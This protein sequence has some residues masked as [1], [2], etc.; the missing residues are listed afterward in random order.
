MKPTQKD[1]TAPAV[2]NILVNKFSTLIA[3]KSN[4]P[5]AE[6]LLHSLIVR[7]CCCCCCLLLL[8][9]L[10]S[11]LLWLLLLLLLLLLLSLFVCL[12]FFVLFFVF[13]FLFLF[14]NAIIFSCCGE[15]IS[16]FNTKTKLTKDDRLWT[17][18]QSYIH[19][20]VITYIGKDNGLIA[21]LFFNLNYSNSVDMLRYWWSDSFGCRLVRNDLYPG[22]WKLSNHS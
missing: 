4:Y 18:T 8:L 19:S 13:L 7:V 11:S 1:K 9:L 6:W 3:L 17:V 5:K 20:W 15:N 21:I 22:I 14:L 16:Y 12:F 10:L 2:R